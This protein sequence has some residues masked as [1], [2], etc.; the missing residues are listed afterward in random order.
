[1]N[2]L[3]TEFSEE[4][5]VLRVDVQSSVGKELSKKYSSRTTPTFILFDPH[6][7]EMWRSIG[8]LDLE[9]VRS[10]ILPNN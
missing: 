7:E 6:G 9:K 3:E 8:I 2:R 1:M 4:L 10:S 5:I